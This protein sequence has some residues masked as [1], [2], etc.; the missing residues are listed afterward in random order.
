MSEYIFYLFRHLKKAYLTAWAFTYLTAILAAPGL[1]GNLPQWASAASMGLMGVLILLNLYAFNSRLLW[2][3][4]GVRASYGAVASWTLI[5]QWSVPYDPVLAGLFM[6]VLDMIAAVLF[7]SY[8]FIFSPPDNQPQ[9][10]ANKADTDQAGG[11]MSVNEE[12][13]GY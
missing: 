9:G 10:E 4:L 8:A 13:T 6:A 5:T 12:I 3:L 11:D 7:F 2:L 1:V